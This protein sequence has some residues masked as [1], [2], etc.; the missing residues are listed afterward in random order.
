LHA[1][2]RLLDTAAAYGNEE[3]V[4]RAIRKSG[5]PREELFITTKL[6]VQDASY[7]STKATFAKSLQKLE[8]DYLDLDLIHQ[9][10]GDV[11]GA[12]RAMEEL[13]HAGKI[14]SIGV[15]NFLKP[16]FAFDERGFLVG[17]YNA[18]H[19]APEELA[20]ALSTARTN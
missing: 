6:W 5:V 13:Y 8:L 19:A 7:E 15:S 14:R 1:G 2:Y 10:Y 12:W 18:H 4:G 11:Y 20:Y 16:E 3:A 9:P 17:A